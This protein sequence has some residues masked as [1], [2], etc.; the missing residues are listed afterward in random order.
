MLIRFTGMIRRVLAVSIAFL[1]TACLS[2]SPCNAQLATSCKTVGGMRNL[3]RASRSR[4]SETESTT[5][6]WPWARSNSTLLSTAMSCDP[7]GFAAIVKLHEF[8]AELFALFVGE[9]VTLGPHLFG[10]SSARCFFG[11]LGLVRL[12]GH[13][14]AIIVVHLLSE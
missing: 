12:R 3:A 13:N 6:S 9:F 7:P 10:Q 8:L 2:M 5:S 4:I 1:A 11:R 14:L